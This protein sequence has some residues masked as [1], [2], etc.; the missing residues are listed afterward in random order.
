MCMQCTVKSK[1]EKEGERGRGG[2]KERDN[3]YD[4]SKLDHLGRIVL[5]SAAIREGV[6]AVV[7]TIPARL[8]G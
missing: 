8:R 5:E 2:P 4:V 3:C 1:S 6:K 7:I